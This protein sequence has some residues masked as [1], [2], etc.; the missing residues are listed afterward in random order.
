VELLPVPAQQAAQY[1]VRVGISPVRPGCRALA[2]RLMESPDS[3]LARAL[4]QPLML[5]L[6]RDRLAMDDDVRELIELDRIGDR[7]GIEGN[8][9]DRVV[10]LAYQPTTAR[11]ARITLETA[12]RA[13]DFFAANLTREAVRDFA[14]WD[15]PRW[16]PCGP[17]MWFTAL[18]A[19]LLWGI[20]N[21]V[22]VLIN[23]W[24]LGPDFGTVREALISVLVNGPDVAMLAGLAVAQ[25]GRAAA[26]RRR[27]AFSRAVIR[28]SCVSGLIIAIAD[29]VGRGVKYGLLDVGAWAVLTLLLAKP[30]SIRRSGR[31]LTLAVDTP[32]TLSIPAGIFGIFVGGIINYLPDGIMSALIGSVLNALTDGVTG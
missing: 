10:P 25:P 11:P 3:A 12:R 7:E 22:C 9:L 18:L 8:L 4:A 16:L 19:G 17:R 20:G 13:L 2:A 5:A 23:G 26:A 6:L 14:W 1:L 21:G 15:I 24:S 28:L 30:P 27:A 29:G 32:G 31:R